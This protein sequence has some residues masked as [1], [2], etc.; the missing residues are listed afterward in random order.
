[1]K[2]VEANY[3]FV[4]AYLV[5]EHVSSESEPL[6]VILEKSN[7]FIGNTNVGFWAYTS[8]DAKLDVVVSKGASLN[9]SNNIG[10]VPPNVPSGVVLGSTST[11]LTVKNGGAVYA[12]GNKAFDL[13]GA[14]GDSNQFFPAS[15]KHYT[16]DT[17]EDTDGFECMNT[18][19]VC[20]LN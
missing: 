10:P 20:E 6:K 5:A 11:H 7:S 18:C 3:N 1:M 13:S 16:C 15:G 2:E 9:A 8:P 17:T 4:G 19:P 12:C 14:E